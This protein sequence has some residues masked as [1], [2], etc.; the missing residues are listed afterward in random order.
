[1]SLWKRLK[2]QI[3]SSG[4]KAESYPAGTT[5]GDKDTIT[6]IRELSRAIMD[7]PDAVE[8]Y[9]ALGNL[10]RA[11]GDVERAVQ[12]RESLLIRP[13]LSSALKGKT[14]FELGQDYRR[15]GLLDRAHNAYMEAE[16]L[17]IPSVQISA[18]LALL[19]SSS[20]NWEKA[21][22]YFYAVGNNAAEAHYMVRQGTELLQNNRQEVKKALRIFNKALKIYPA[23]IEGWSALVIEYAKLGKWGASAKA[24]SKALEHVAP[25]KTFMLFEEVLAALPAQQE[26]QNTKEY[27]IA[28]D[29]F[30]KK[31]TEAFIPVL[32][33]RPPELFP[34][35]YGAML[36]KRSNQ[37][38]E[39]EQWLDKSLVMQ[40]NFWQGRLMHLSL[41]RQQTTLPPLFDTD[42]DFFLNQ[43]KH[44]KRF[45]C[46]ACGLN[47]DQ[48][49][50]SC[51]RC[52]SWH[53]ATY[54]FTLNE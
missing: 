44:V 47:R 20:G 21:C 28:C 50:Y 35:F 48:L 5:P 13:E 32:A 16:R 45:V 23:S 18:E 8:I 19:Y 46:S 39:A 52:H 42:L 26:N 11:R 6:A 37:L 34:N 43:S 9:L 54:K 31:M 25:E 24:L 2:N 27:R 51:Q 33:K 14:Y 49:F 7:N 41:A 36:L 10:Y 15:A 29:Q 40:P 3:S 53:S 1:M 4:R 17:G 22:E 12:I 30:Y 38:E